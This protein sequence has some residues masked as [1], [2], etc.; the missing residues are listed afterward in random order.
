MKKMKKREDIHVGHEGDD[1]RRHIRRCGTDC[2]DRREQQHYDAREQETP[3]TP[4]QKI[5]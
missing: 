3:E 5:T 4:A 2:V 1:G